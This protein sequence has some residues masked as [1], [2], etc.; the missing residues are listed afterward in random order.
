MTPYDIVGVLISPLPILALLASVALSLAAL[1][2]IA[3]RAFVQIRMVRIATGYLSVL[4]SMALVS[5]TILATNGGITPENFIGFVVLFAYMACWMVAVI[6]LPLVI[7]LTARGRGVVGWVLLASSAVGA[8]IF[9]V[10]TYLISSR[11]IA[12][13]TAQ[14]WTYDLLGAVMLMAIISGAFSIGAR[15]PWAKSRLSV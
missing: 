15:L 6:V 1:Y 9:T 5:A 13:I 2:V 10:S 14:Q 3:R 11:N 7:A 4:V 8:P 12:N